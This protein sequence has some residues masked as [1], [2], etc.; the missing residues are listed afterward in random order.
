MELHEIIVWFCSG[1]IILRWTNSLTMSLE[2]P[3]PDIC[4]ISLAGRTTQ[5]AVK[6]LVETELEDVYCGKRKLWNLCIGEAFNKFLKNMYVLWQ[7]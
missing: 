3:Q 7:N 1:T 2:L 5:E 6:E 4:Y